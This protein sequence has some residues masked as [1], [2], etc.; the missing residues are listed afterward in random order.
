[1]FYIHGGAFKALSKDT[2]WLMGMMFARAGFLVVNINYRLAPHH[3]CPAALSDLAEAY[4]WL[5]ANISQYG[6]DPKRVV[7]AGE[8]AGA[9][10]GLSLSW[11]IHSGL[12]PSWAGP[13]SEVPYP[14]LAVLPACGLFSVEDSGRFVRDWGV[15]PI[16]GRILERV[17]RVVQNPGAP[18]QEW[19]S[20]LSMMERSPERVRGF[21]P[22]M[23]IIGGRD[24]LLS[25]S[26]R[27]CR[28]L[29]DAKVPV[30]LRVY[31]NEVHAFH[32]FIWR[33][34]ARLA[35]SEMFSFVDLHLQ[36]DAVH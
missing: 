23:M 30:N 28:L 21:P 34:H 19:A 18:E 3:P 16:Y 6:G 15:R 29:R 22:T 14:P 31:P 1:V 25:D 5:H 17:S 2:H 12:R 24:P 32:A 36:G 20:P 11:A 9:N 26:L 13:L 27:L 8:S 33:H 35:W 4:H 7:I 10:L